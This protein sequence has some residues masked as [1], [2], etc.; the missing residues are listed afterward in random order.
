MTEHPTATDGRTARRDRGRNQVLDA[1]I[2]LFTEGNL[3][4]TPEQVAALAGVSGRTVYRYFEDR[5]ALVRASIDR[6]FEQI[7]PLVVVPHLGEGSLDERIHRLVRTR[8]TL[9]DA[10]AAAYRA[11]S[12]KAPTDPMLA[13]RLDFGRAALREQVELQFSNELDQLDPEV[14]SLRVSALELLT[15]FESIDGLRNVRGRSARATQAVLRDAL[16]ALLRITSTTHEN[17]TITEERHG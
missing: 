12:A 8:V 16:G 3:D 7:E 14:R 4:P 9:H 10:V 11:A 17:D 15:G 6:H 1:V 13:D 5:S 2:E